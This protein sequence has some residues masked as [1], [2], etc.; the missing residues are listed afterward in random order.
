MEGS[1]VASRP[2]PFFVGE[3]PAL[4]F[5]NT[6]A[7]PSGEPIE[8]IGNGGDLLAWLERAQLVLA[9]VARRFRRAAEASELDPIADRGRALREWLRGFVRKR[10]GRPL[11][12]VAVRELG[13]LNHL[14]AR[15][16]TYRQLEPV[17]AAAAKPQTG[18]VVQW[19]AE[20]RWRTVEALLEPIA[21][22][23]GDFLCQ[24]D[25]RYV[26]RCERCTLWFYDVSRGHRRRWCSMAVC[27][28]R[29]KA[30][31]HRARARA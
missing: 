3:H 25:F 7:S 5:L 13:R 1:V 20:R 21:E 29:A 8:W 18:S 31:N 2:V 28:N 27:G 24:A 30:A 12:P 23:I 15:D 16:E 11:T 26:R 4:D 9:P 14:L 22:A 10:A 17:R 6:V 19:R